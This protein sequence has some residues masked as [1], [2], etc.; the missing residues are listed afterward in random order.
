MQTCMY[1]KI[2]RGSEAV[3]YVSGYKSLLDWL[4]DF[5][6]HIPLKQCRHFL[7]LTTNST[8]AF[9]VTVAFP[10]ST[11]AS[12]SMQTLILLEWGSVQIKLA[13][14]ILRHFD[15]KPL[16][17]LRQTDIKPGLSNSCD[18]QRSF[19]LIPLLLTCHFA[20]F[21]H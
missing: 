8:T 6:A 7:V 1:K 18:S 17:F 13:S 19:L 4:Q 10:P 2:R 16:I 15:D 14:R 21:E 3:G 9:C 12:S 11:S 5:R 20:Q